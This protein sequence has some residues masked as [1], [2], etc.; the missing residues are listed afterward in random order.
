MEKFKT[1]FGLDK[2]TIGRKKFVISNLIIFLA[3][4]TAYVLFFLVDNSFIIVLFFIILFFYIWVLYGTA[5][6]RLKDIGHN[7][8]LAYLYLIPYAGLILLLYL[9]ITQGKSNKDVI[10]NS[11]SKKVLKIILLSII[12]IFIMGV[13][14]AIILSSFSTA[15]EKAELNSYTSSILLEL[16]PSIQPVG[17]FDDPSLFDSE[18]ITDEDWFSHLVYYEVEKT[19]SNFDNSKTQF[20]NQREVFGSIV[21]IVCEDEEYFYYGSG[22]NLDGSGL[23]LTNRHVIQEMDRDS[24][25]IGFPNPESGLIEEAYWA[26]PIF[27]EDDI[28]GHDLAYLSI[29]EPVFDGDNNIYGYYEKLWEGSFPFFDTPDKCS[30]SSSQ[31]G[32]EIFIIGY[33]PLSGGSL[34][35]TNGLISSLYSPN[36]YL[37]TSAKI[38]SGNSGGSAIDKEGC[39]VGVPTAIY[40]EEESEYLGEIIDAEFIGEFVEATFDDLDDYNNSL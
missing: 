16:E 5:F 20:P 6:R 34:T 25:V 18:T 33:P 40:Y 17:Y 7:K 39:F 2:E 15:R 37:I 14:S 36:G 11:T 10:N 3:L 19:N 35:I 38:V 30:L 23:V 1:F 4:I 27:D 32:D 28:T 8:D 21:K 29:E 12:G 24:C 13:F 9:S 22:T 31:L 26:T